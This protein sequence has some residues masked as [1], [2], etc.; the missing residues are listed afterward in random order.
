MEEKVSRKRAREVKTKRWS[1]SEVNK[2]LDYMLEHKNVE[3]RACRMGVIFVAN[4]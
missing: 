2:V 3:V 4:S 1:E